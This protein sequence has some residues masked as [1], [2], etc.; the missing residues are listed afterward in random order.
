ME[1]SPRMNDPETMRM[2]W[3]MKNKQNQLAKMEYN[4]KGKFK[5]ILLLIMFTDNF[6]RPVVE[7]QTLRTGGHYLSQSIDFSR[8]GP[9]FNQSYSR[10]PK[11]I[12]DYS[13]QNYDALNSSIQINDHMYENMAS[14]TP[15]FNVRKNVVTGDYMKGRG[16]TDFHNE[17]QAPISSGSM[18]MHIPQ[19]FVAKSSSAINY[20]PNSSMRG[21][22]PSMMN[23]M[24]A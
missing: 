8:G 12:L 10:L 9:D 3:A 6:V 14:S 4:S 1:P 7:N 15:K 22:N 2:M 20:N 11:P 23:Q 24:Y 18:G 19:T 5:G 17:M 16:L 21:Y 13:K